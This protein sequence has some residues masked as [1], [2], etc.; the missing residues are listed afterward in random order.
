MSEDDDPI[1]KIRLAAAR[2]AAS[3]DWLNG[4][5]LQAH[6]KGASLREIAK[7]AGVSHEQVRRLIRSDQT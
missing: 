7:A 6:A 4:A 1:Q 2:A 5:I 3:R